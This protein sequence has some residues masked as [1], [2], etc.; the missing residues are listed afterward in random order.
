[1]DELVQQISSNTGADPSSA[2][3]AV[4][5]IL[6]FLLSEA[7][8]TGAQELVDKIPGA[9]EAIVDAPD[10]SGGGVMGVFSSLKA[11]GLG[12]GEI[13]AVVGELV[14]FANAKVG[15]HTVRKMLGSIP[16]LTQFV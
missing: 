12:I 6:K 3:I 8:E 10:I 15:E 1:M 5:I 11:T 13:Q 14:S 4:G 9:R 7:G 2:R 16:G